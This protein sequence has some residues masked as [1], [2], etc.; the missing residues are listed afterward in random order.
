M[1]VTAQLYGQFLVSS[2][3]NYTG[4]YLADHLE[5]LTHDNVRYFLKTSR[6]TPRQLWQQVRPQVVFSTRG[7]V[8][9]DDTVLDKHHRRRIELVRRQY[10]GNAHG[11]IAGIGL[12]TCVYVNPETDQFWLIDYRLFAPDGDGKTKLEHVADML[13][14]L[15]PRGITYRTVLMD[16]WYATTALFKWLLAAGKTFYCPLKSNRL[17]DDSGGQRPYQPVGCLC[18]SN[19]EVAQGKILKV[20]GMP[21][22]CKLKLFRVL[23]SPHRTD[24]HVTNE[25]EPCETAAAE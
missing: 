16:S 6:F 10:S 2:Q 23:V 3:V 19:E 21:K 15:A 20:K 25:V 14:Q 12:V 1:K 11:V 18:W 9:F 24:Y 22:D 17:V 7:Y 4:T 5:G 8:L 13:A